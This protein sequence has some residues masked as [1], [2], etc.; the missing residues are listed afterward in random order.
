MVCLD[1]Q[2]A[3]VKLVML[4]VKACLDTQVVKACLDTQVVKAWLA[5]QV[6]MAKLVMLAA[7]ACLD[8]QAAKALDIQAVKALDIQVVKVNLDL[9]G[10]LDH[11]V[12]LVLLDTLVQLALLVHWGTPE[13]MVKQDT[14]A[15][16][17]FK[18]SKE[19]MDILGHTD[20]RA[21]LAIQGQKDM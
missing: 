12:R 11:K 19:L 17:A 13:A 7:K 9:L 4:A 5:T 6:A 15:R 14:P 8:T 16:K 2:V 3:M 10:S 20:H 1:T 18:E 21:T